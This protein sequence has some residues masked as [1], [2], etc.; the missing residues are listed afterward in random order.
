MPAEES[1]KQPPLLGLLWPYEIP[2]VAV[3]AYGLFFQT[4]STLRGSPWTVP[5]F[6]AA[7]LAGVVMLALRCPDEWRILPNKAVFFISAAAWVAL[8]TFLGNSTFGYV[9]TNSIFAWVFDI[10]T[11]PDSEA[12]Y[13][14]L[15]PF[16]V[17]ALFWWKRRELVAGTPGTWA[18]ALGLVIAG[19]F[20]HLVGY[21]IQR[22]HLSF[23]GFFTGLYGL[24]GLAWGKN[25]LKRSFFPFFLLAFCIPTVGTDWLT[26][27]MRLLV[28]WIVAGIAHLGLAPDLVRDGT[29]LLDAQHTFGYEVAAACSGI[30]SLTA[31]LALT[32]IYGF[33]CFKSPWKRAVMV[34]SAFPLAI[35]GNVLRLCFTI[36][37][38]EL[39]GQDAGKAVETKAGFITFAVAIAC[40]YFLGRWLERSES[41]LPETPEPASAK[42]VSGRSGPFFAGLVLAL[43]GVTAMLIFH[44][45]SQ[46]R[47][48]EPGVKTRPIAGSRR[49]EVLMPPTVPGYT[50]EILTNAETVL[51]NQ[52]PK[53]SSYRALVYTGEDKFWIQMTA[54]LMGA[55]RTS[56]HSP[57]ICLVGQGWAIDSEHTTIDSIKMERPHAYDLPVNKLLA[58]KQ[59]TGTDGKTQTFRGI[60]VYWY[61]DGSHFTPNEKLWSTWWMPRDLLLHGLLERWSYI[62]VF[63]P[64]LPGQEDATYDR[65]KKLIASAVPEFQLVPQ[66]GG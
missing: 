5:W 6:G 30:R 9:N 14:L 27:R 34:L 15:M 63:V 35:L 48:G 16:V 23:A 28:A 54:V 11:A 42:K 36:M 38:A 56:I 3:M 61:V 64:C 41:A 7:I 58:T 39:C 49:L 60:Y 47:L 52:L 31:L 32:T 44:I 25:W 18:P 26:L 20:M 4:S 50:S 33:V 51:E 8:F 53:D 21:V 1:K 65:M 62:S 29:Q 22:P 45:K 46:Q 2:L 57:Y 10:Y 43:M 17:L 24:T 55:D 19:L 37:V 59:V 13:A 66:G 12:E 40:V